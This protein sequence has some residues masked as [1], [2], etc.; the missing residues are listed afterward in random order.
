MSR[1]LF[2][3]LEGIDGAGKSVQTE[4]VTH[5]LNQ[6]GY[7]AI[8]TKEPSDSFFG[9][10]L[11]YL[12]KQGQSTHKELL[13]LFTAD[14][15]IHFENEILPAISSGKIIICDRYYYS[16]AAYQGV[17][18]DWQ[19]IFK[20]QHDLFLCPDICFLIDISAE[21]SLKRRPVNRLQIESKENLKMVRNIYCKLPSPMFLI[22]GEKSEE[23]ITNIIVNEILSLIKYLG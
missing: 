12:L 9:S 2:I 4:R 16:T 19:E 13:G 23:E 21:T 11:K 6:L 8:A 15:A 7:D 20:N 1:G 18:G 5:R 14:R 10:R 3:V 22:N 17:E